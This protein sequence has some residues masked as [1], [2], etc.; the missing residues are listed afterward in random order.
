[1][2][3]ETYKNT[4]YLN[5]E[6]KRY[7]VAEDIIVGG[8]ICDVKDA[9][10]LRRDLGISHVINVETEHTDDGVWPKYLLEV[11]V[12]DNGTPFPK[13]HVVAAMTFAQLC[14]QMHGEL[15][16]HCQE[17]L[18]RGPSF[19]YAI[20]RSRGLSPIDALAKVR[21]AKGDAGWGTYLNHTA[22]IYLQSVEEALKG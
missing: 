18:N 11:R 7:R 17:G 13:E 6:C 1:M 8:S 10:H 21:S 22:T 15:Y 3:V 5:H 20:L 9:E 19:A 4:R 14:K 2:H 12:P 16:V